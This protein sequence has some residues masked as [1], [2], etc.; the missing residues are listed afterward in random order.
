MAASPV[1]PHRPNVDVSCEV[2]VAPCAMYRIPPRL[3]QLLAE[4]PATQCPD[5]SSVTAECSS[6]LA[7]VYESLQ[8]TPRDVPSAKMRTTTRFVEAATV[9]QPA[10]ALPAFE[11]E[12]TAPL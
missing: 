1:V 10:V 2:V 11:H 3:S 7:P 12:V 9:A 6:A 5:P 8:D 4:L